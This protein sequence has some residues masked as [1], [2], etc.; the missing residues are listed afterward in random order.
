MRKLC[1]VTA[2]AAA[3]FVL[4]PFA[5]AQVDS[6]TLTHGG[7][8]YEERN[9]RA[10]NT[11][12]TGGRA[13]FISPGGT[14]HMF[15]NWWW[16][17]TPFSGREFA[18]SNMV[19][20]STTGNSA[21]I[22]FIEDGGPNSPDSLLFDLEYTLTALPGG[23]S[24][25]VQIGWKIHNL[26]NEAQTVNFFSYSDFDLNATS[27]NDTGVFIAPNQ[28]DIRDASPFVR[29]GLVA[30]NS[31]LSGWE[32]SVWPTLI[33]K[34]TDDDL[35]LL[36]NAT[37]PLGPDDL[38]HGFSW[39]FTLSANGSANGG[40]QMVG[41]LL[42]YVVVPEPATMTAFGLASLALLARRRKR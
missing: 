13:D 24:A 39:S 37:S 12:D 23:Q 27:E 40:D 25:L 5:S 30:S 10:D 16:F 15:Q 18:L 1:F 32:Q 26:S 21:R 38:T 33:D 34:L 19:S 2:S 28:M 31:R 41:S 11:G 29:G 14:D 7:W 20:S 3:T 8:T 36:A 9:L 6:F 35:D 4:A 22:V 17:S 42:K